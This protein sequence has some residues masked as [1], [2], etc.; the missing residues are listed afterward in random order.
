M[1]ALAVLGLDSDGAWSTSL[2]LLAGEGGATVVHARP[3]NQ[4]PDGSTL[5]ATAP[6]PQSPTDNQIIGIAPTP[7]L[8]C[9]VATGRFVSSTFEYHF[10]LWA[11]AADGATTRVEAGTVPPSTGRAIYPI[12]SGLRDG[13]YRWRV[14]AEL[15]GFV[16]PWSAWAT[17]ILDSVRVEIFTAADGT[18]FRVD[19][20]ATGLEVPW[21]M[22]FAPDGRLFVTERPGRVR[23]IE[24]GVLLPEPALTL[25]DVYAQVEAGALGLA[26]HPQFAL[27]R[28]VYL[29]YT[30]ERPGQS[31]VNRLVRYRELANTLREGVVLFDGPLGAPTHDGARVRFGPDGKLYVTMGD[32]R[33]VSLPQD[34]AAFNG[35][36]LRLNENGTTPSDNPFGSPVLS[37]GHRNPQGIDWHPV[38]GDL[39]ATEHGDVGNDELN[40]IDGGSNYG[41]PVIEGGESMAGMQTPIRSYSPSIAPSGAS[42]YTGSLFPT[43]RNDMFFATLVGQHVHLVRFDPA[44]VRRVVGDERLLEGR[45]GRIR[46]VVTG[47]DG[48]LYFATNNRDGRGVP[49]V[50]D[51]RI[52]RIVPAAPSVGGPAPRRRLNIVRLLPSVEDRMPLLGESSRSR[53]SP[54]RAAR[55][56]SA[57]PRPQ[58]PIPVDR[59]Y[60]RPSRAS[61]RGW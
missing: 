35:K 17:F 53:L 8:I 40:V 41:W 36:I 9:T 20:V 61:R 48:A 12:R 31:P 11:I 49:A 32:V 39:W 13:G 4:A 2:R 44:D 52:L 56:A 24:N 26:V 57:A 37:Y 15:E 14:R 19:V 21:A 43:F 3:A 7:E 27:N 29:V 16:G 5:T 6:L 47:P 42:F 34:L 28:Y 22:A 10:E 33:D 1:I 18:R 55:P 51:D 59:P 25:T 54:H 23:I 45:F 50:D 46:D 30:A 60:W 58:S 38:S